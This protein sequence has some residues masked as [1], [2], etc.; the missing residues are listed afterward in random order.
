MTR[1]ISIPYET[2]ENT[3]KGKSNEKI[4][5]QNI[6]EFRIYITFLYMSKFLLK[7]LLFLKNNF[8]DKS[9]LRYK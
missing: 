7:Q 2:L 3:L 4:L 1:H 6:F 5:L 9:I 8:D